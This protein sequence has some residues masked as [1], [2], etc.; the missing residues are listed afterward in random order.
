MSDVE[1]RS[2]ALRLRRRHFEFLPDG[3]RRVEFLVVLYFPCD[4]L[5]TRKEKAFRREILD[6]LKVKLSISEHSSGGM[7]FRQTRLLRFK[8]CGTFW[9]DNMPQ[10]YLGSHD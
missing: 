8:S 10:H 5:R 9:T 2:G 7:N 1:S 4:L 6:I 3:Y